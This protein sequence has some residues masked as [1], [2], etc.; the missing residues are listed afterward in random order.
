MDHGAHYF[1]YYLNMCILM[2]ITFLCR[3]LLLII[4]IILFRRWQVSRKKKS[5]VTIV[6]L[7]DV[8]RSPRMQYHA[9]SLAQHGFHVNM[10][11]YSDSVP[12]KKILD[13]DRIILHNLKKETISKYFPGM[14]TYIV[15]VLS[16]TFTLSVK[17]L[18]EVGASE[19]ILMQNPP[20]IPSMFV[21]WVFGI[22]N[23]SRVIIDWHNYGYTILA[24]SLG[25]N[26][27]LVKIAHFYE[28]VI[29]QLA[30]SE[31]C[32]TEAM[33]R[34]LEKNWHIHA[35]VLYD[36]PPE[37]FRPLDIKESHLFFSRL[38]L[39]YP[40][41]SAYPDDENTTFC[42]LLKDGLVVER[43]NRP[44]F[45]I[46]ST[47]WTEDE[48][49]GILLNA[50]KMY[51]ATKSSESWQ[52]LPDIICAITGKGPMKNFYLKQ[53]GE[54]DWKHVKIITPW[55]VAEDYPLLVGS[56]DLGI[57]LHTSSSGLDLPMKVVDMFGCGVPVA[58]IGFNC[59]DE[60]VKDNV[61]GVIFHNEK[62]LHD[63]L[64]NLLNGFPKNQTLLSN[65]RTNLISF[66]QSTWSKNWD[67]NVLPLFKS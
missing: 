35:I 40:Q 24:M 27:K 41:F 11:G 49:F 16:Q 36:R 52:K 47:S 18:V 33:Q 50:L 23:G 6:V 55:L 54:I 12:N 39:E 61:N 28:K 19:Y 42:S 30:Y 38:K 20:C 3:L 59:L 53:M 56:A 13:S 48:D 26:H 44:A 31:I 67:E 9:L 7:G 25:K 8:G 29:G 1:L 21:C 62:G 10:V 65:M 63:Q 64:C 34:D 46:S 45:I 2:P 66:R 58:A 15:K 51:D 4:I 22:L 37:N 5:R 43:D 57:C 32:V 17:L 60:L 14:L